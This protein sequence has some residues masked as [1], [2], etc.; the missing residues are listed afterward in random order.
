M[1]TKCN[2]IHSNGDRKIFCRYYSA[3]LDHAV[4]SSWRDWDCSECQLKMTHDEGQVVQITDSGTIPYYEL[5][6]E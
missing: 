3:C 6:M 2:P 5:L 4:K 1:D